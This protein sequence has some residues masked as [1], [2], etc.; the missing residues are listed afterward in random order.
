MASLAVIRQGASASSMKSA[1]RGMQRVLDAE[2][3]GFQM[4]KRMGWHSGAIGQS[5]DGIV[6][7]I[8]PLANPNALTSPRRSGIGNANGYGLRG[9]GKL[10]GNIDGRF[11][12]HMSA[13]SP[14]R[15]RKKKVSAVA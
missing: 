2:N 12:M 13:S 15:N 8:D 7:P 4:L 6:E 14:S 11:G 5:Q 9:D 1:A 10:R 3:K